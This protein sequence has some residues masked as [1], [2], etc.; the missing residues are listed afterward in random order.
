MASSGSVAAAASSTINA[1]G[2][3]IR[4]CCWDLKTLDPAAARVQKITSALPTR[5]RCTWL[6]KPFLLLEP[7]SNWFTSCNSLSTS[8]GSCLAFRAI[9]AV[10][11]LP[12]SRDVW[13]FSAF[14]L[15]FAGKRL[16]MSTNWFKRRSSFD[17]EWWVN[18]LLLLVLWEATFPF[19][20]ALKDCSSACR[21]ERKWYKKMDRIEACSFWLVFVLFSFA[22]STSSNLSGSP[23]N[24]ILR[25][26]FF[27]CCIACINRNAKTAMALL[28]GAVTM[29]GPGCCGCSSDGKGFKRQRQM[30]DTKNVVLP[31][32]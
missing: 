10:V 6:I 19:K 27:P 20:C 3:C 8:L 13:R 14:S 30:M 7:C 18:S 2:R 25:L 21:L 9:A 22:S 17:H 1:R 15:T 28:V 24:T 12:L 23:T 31:F 29:M 4:G 11:V 32:E 5:W 16:P 26:L